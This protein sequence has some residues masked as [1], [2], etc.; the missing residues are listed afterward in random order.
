[1]SVCSLLSGAVIVLAVALYAIGPDPRGWNATCQLDPA[2]VA[3][4]A[5]H[6]LDDIWEQVLQDTT[7]AM[8]LPDAISLTRLFWQGMNSTFDCADDVLPAG[9][10]KII[11]SVGVVAKVALRSSGD[12]P[13]TGLFTGADYGLLRMST[14]KRPTAA[15]IYPAMG[16]KLFRSGATSGN[17]LFLVAATG[18]DSCQFGQ[19]NLS[20]M[21]ANS[22]TPF[23]RL[24]DMKLS[25]SGSVP[26]RNSLWRLASE[27]QA[28]HS[29]ST[30]RVP[31]HLVLKFSHP[32]FACDGKLAENFMAERNLELSLFAVDQPGS[33][34]L[35]IGEL[36]LQSTFTTSKFADTRLF[37]S[38]TRSKRA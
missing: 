11:H 29:V 14:A 23:M 28:G 4:P 38:H 33:A 21:V 12:H 7:P 22:T 19:F 26:T 31:H 10:T 36:E 17:A 2:A 5:A 6:K 13:Y 24:L 9:K 37:F 34:A 1:M 3:K 32:V 15:R 18:Q 20:T 30:P 35:R 27:D 16:L 8:W 25:T